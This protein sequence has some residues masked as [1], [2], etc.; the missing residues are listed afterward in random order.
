MTERADRTAL[1]FVG[2]S[3]TEWYDWGGRFPS[4]DVT[5]LGI[6]GETVE[7]LLERRSL[8]RARAGTPDRVF[9][10]SGINNILQERYQI[11]APYREIVR[12]F[13]TW[14]RKA[15]VVVQSLLPVEYP[16]I[17]N[18]LIRDINRQLREIA[19]EESASYLDVHAAFVDPA[20]SVKRGL[21]SD[22]GV[23]LSGNG[24][25]TWSNAVERF[26]RA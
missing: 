12:N 22:D 3:L 17:S 7:E 13:A 11:T 4:Y 9:L 10:M 2:D 19:R 23:H 21:L 14:W 18:D 15:T 20:G 25:T 8:I 1:V 5:N 6:S 16:W 26:L 24:Y